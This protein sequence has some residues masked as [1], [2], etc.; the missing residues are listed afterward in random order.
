MTVTYDV[1]I[2][3]PSNAFSASTYHGSLLGQGAPVTYTAEPRTITTTGS[4]PPAVTYRV[5]VSS[6]NVEQLQTTT[7]SADITFPLS[8]G[9]NLSTVIPV[10]LTVSSAS[11]S[12]LT[13]ST[14]PTTVLSSATST[15][16]ISSS[17]TS[18]LDHTSIAG[19]SSYPASRPT[20]FSPFPN[21]STTSGGTSI[22]T[23]YPVS[24]TGSSSSS[25]AVGTQQVAGSNVAELAGVAIG[26]LIGGALIASLVFFLLSRRRRSRHDRKS[27]SSERELSPLNGHG[28]AIYLAGGYEKAWEKQL[29]SNKSDIATS[30]MVR[31]T[32]DQ[33]E[34]FVDTFYQDTHGLDLSI[35]AQSEL[36]DLDSSHLPASILTLISQAKRPSL[37]IKH[38]LINFILS[39]IIPGGTR[40]ATSFLPK[41]FA[42]MEPSSQTHAGLGMSISYQARNQALT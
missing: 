18:G 22:T 11:T 21:T 14:T 33:I 35:E 3:P 2:T 4:V 28:E 42:S 1:I 8:P 37:L 5:E 31:S 25:T 20:S 24:G 13:S 16:A 9:P 39:R 23:E 6:Q 27:S 40:V 19:I 7:L 30:H 29:P 12:T 34:V 26:C 32:L 10:E 41:E 36:E 15:I 38:C 17:S